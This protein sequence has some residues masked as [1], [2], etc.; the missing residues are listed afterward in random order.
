MRIDV[1]WWPMVQ[2]HHENGVMWAESPDVPGW[3]AAAKDREEMDELLRE[4]RESLF[5]LLG[6]P[7]RELR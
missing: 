2:F 7:R 3:S 6:W 5:R 1:W 4:A